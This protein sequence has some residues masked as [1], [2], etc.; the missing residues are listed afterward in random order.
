MLKPHGAAFTTLG[1][2]ALDVTH[3]LSSYGHLFELRA[4]LQGENQPEC[5]KFK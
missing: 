5:T 3:E 2:D 1:A 4:F